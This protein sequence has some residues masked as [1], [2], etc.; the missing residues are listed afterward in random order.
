MMMEKLEYRTIV[1]QQNTKY[2]IELNHLTLPNLY[3][4]SRLGDRLSQTPYIYVQLSSTTNTYDTTSK[5]I[6]N[7]KKLA[8]GVFKLLTTDVSSLDK[9]RFIK[10]SNSVD[11]SHFIVLNSKSELHFRL[12]FET[13]EDLITRTT[14]NYLPANADQDVQISANFKLTEIK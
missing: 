3:I 2:K 8:N 13:N 1:S 4:N 14:D 10:L 7:N 12:F 6:T 9:S 5:T 11:S